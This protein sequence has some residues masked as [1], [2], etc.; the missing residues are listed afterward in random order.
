MQDQQSSVSSSTESYSISKIKKLIDLNNDMTNFKLTFR[1][2]SLE[3]LPFHAL[4]VDQSTL[5]NKGQN[6]MEF[7]TVEGS[8]SGEVVADKNVYQNYF[9]ILA[10]ETPQAVE[11]EI[12][13]ERLPDYIE[14]KE[15]TVSTDVKTDEN[16]MS[17]INVKYIFIGI[18]IAILIYVLYQRQSDGKSALPKSSLKQSLLQK[19]KQIPLQ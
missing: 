14:K 16:I 2:T 6:E 7:K 19:L 3:N 9:M 1:V 5:D 17:S 8:L 4:I 10:S 12:T 18:V 11:V 15:D 13:K